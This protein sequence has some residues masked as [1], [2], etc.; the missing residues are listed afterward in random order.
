MKISRN[1][2]AVLIT[3]S[4]IVGSGKSTSAKRTCQWL[5][6]Q[7]FPVTYL[8][9]RRLRW[10][11]FFQPAGQRIGGALKNRLDA[12]SSGDHTLRQ[13]RVRTLGLAHV[14]LYLWR[15]LVFRIYL[16]TRLRARIVV[17]DRYFWDNL[18]HYHL[19]SSRERR[20]FRLLCRLIPQPGLSLMLIAGAATIHQRRPN[21]DLQALEGLV[22]R[23]RRLCDMVPGLQRIETDSFDGMDARIQNLLQQKLAIGG[24]EGFASVAD[25]LGAS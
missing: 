20:Y 4:G 13:P 10:R 11:H 6:A 3:F 18:A 7:G 5:Q 25:A 23:Y 16:A 1:G 2:R 9:F 22:T 19:R 17:S 15:A 21:Y 14:A 12:S 24:L 8:R